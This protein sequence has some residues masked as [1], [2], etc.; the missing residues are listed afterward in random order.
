VLNAQDSI[1]TNSFPVKEEFAML[2]NLG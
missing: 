1:S 2:S